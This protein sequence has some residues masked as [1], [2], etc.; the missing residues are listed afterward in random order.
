MKKTISFFISLFAIGFANGVAQD[1]EAYKIYTSKGKEIVFDRMMDEIVSADIVLF[2]EI[3]NDP[4]CHWL[5]LELSKSAIDRK[6]NVVFGAEMFET[7]DQLVID[8][9]LNG[10]ITKD[11]LKKETKAWPNLETDYLPLL[12]LAAEKKKKF[13]ATNIP[14][15][16]ASLASKKGME[17]LD[18]LSDDAKE[19]IC[20]MPHI[21]TAN[22]SGYA[23][24][25]VQ[26]GFHGPGM[27]VESLILAQSL[28]DHTMADNILKNYRQG[29]LFV[30]F[31]GTYH[32]QKFSGIYNYL[33]ITKPELKI[34]VIATIEEDSLEYQNG[35]KTLG[36]FVIVVPSSMTKTH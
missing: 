33:K 27:N 11:Q 8:E 15:R 23:E 1:L 30:H 36:D 16:Y 28:K 18:S 7:D 32:S 19:L 13:I 4:I 12:Q 25:R 22:D 29:E 14:R 24:M 31:H 2:G 3:H 26:M 34:L 20:S 5:Q 35:W 17:A 6:K 10:T 9:F 21:V